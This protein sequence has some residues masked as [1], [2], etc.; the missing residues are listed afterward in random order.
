MTWRSGF[1]LLAHMRPHIRISPFLPREWCFLLQEKNDRFKKKSHTDPSFWLDQAKD[2]KFLDSGR[3]ALLACLEYEDIK[4]NDEVLI[5]TTTG[6][7]YISSCVT[8]TIEKICRW[9]REP[10]AKTRAVLVIHE[11]GFPCPYSV[12]KPYIEKGIPII[13]DCA[14]SIGSRIQGAAVG[15]VGDYAIYSLTKYYPVSFG[16]ILVSRKRLLQN[17]DSRHSEKQSD[18]ESNPEEILRSAQNDRKTPGTLNSV[19]E[20]LLK[21]TIQKASAFTPQWNNLRRKNWEFFAKKL[22]PHKITPYFKLDQK[23]VPGVFL[24]K[25]PEGFRG[26]IRK[27]QLNNAGVE[28]TEYYGQG[29]F[30]FPVHQ[31]LSEYEKNY[32]LHHF[33]TPNTDK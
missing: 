22:R 16:G 20:R 28:A 31:F 2:L 29:G 19:D 11:F 18:E 5:L 6:G 15:G 4:R 12:I 30:Y 25:L 8:K 10:S 33:L 27:R 26:D 3:S 21:Q 13:E 24:A 1:E 7:P 14:Y 23:N 17:I 32:I 9:E